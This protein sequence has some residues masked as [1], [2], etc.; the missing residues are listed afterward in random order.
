MPKFCKVSQDW[1]LLALF[2][3]KNGL[4]FSIAVQI[5]DRIR[6]QKTRCS[7]CQRDLQSL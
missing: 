4:N 5:Y 1:C 3:L 2:G 7:E 6:L